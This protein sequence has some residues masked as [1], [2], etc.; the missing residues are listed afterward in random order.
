MSRTY[1]TISETA[2]SVDEYLDKFCHTRI[3]E[4]ELVYAEYARLWQAI[5]NVLL[6]GGKRVRPYM[7]LLGYR[8]YSGKDDDGVFAVA[9]AQELLH[10]AMLIHDDIIDRDDMRRGQINISGAYNEHYM[11]AVG[12]ITMRRHYAN[13]AAM[14]A[15]DALISEVYALMASLDTSIDK[16]RRAVNSMRQAMFAVVGGELL[17]TEAAFVREAADPK[18]IALHKTAH[19]SFR[20][21]L[22][23]GAILGGASDEA[24]EQLGKVSDQIGLAYQWQD[25]LLGVFGASETTGKSTESDI[26]EG[27][28]TILSEQCL[29]LAT[30]RDKRE[31]VRLYGKPGVT[32]DEIVQVRQIMERSGA[33]DAAGQLV[34]QHYNKALQL[35][36]GLELPDEAGRQQLRQL[37]DFCRQRK[38]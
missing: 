28:H 19:Y 37:V 14:L 12:D 15:G 3:E 33:R 26:R 7:T 5:T 22:T 4:A 24:V 20:A 31:F 17:D 8:L 2:Q 9:I 29:Q 36:A 11:D 23:T 27:K 25:D 21:P 16:R 35:I 32:P 1:P 34:E 13:S 18:T 38:S 30:D 10:T 6:A